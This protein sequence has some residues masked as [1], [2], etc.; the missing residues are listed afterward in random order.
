MLPVEQERKLQNHQCFYCHW[1]LLDRRALAANKY[2]Y[3]NV[4]S[5]TKQMSGSIET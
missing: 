4:A 2:T 1:P 3:A 5:L